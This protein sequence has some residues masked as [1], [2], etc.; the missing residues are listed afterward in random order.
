MSTSAGCCARS[1]LVGF[2]SGVPVIH[3]LDTPGCRSETNAAGAV[4]AAVL[5]R[6]GGRR[7]DVI[8]YRDST[9]QFEGLLVDD[10]DS[11]AGFLPLGGARSLAEALARLPEALAALR[12]PDAQQ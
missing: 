7:A 5:A 10:D 4:V 12:A 11:F 9:G 2:V 6:M 8:V 1:A 3:D